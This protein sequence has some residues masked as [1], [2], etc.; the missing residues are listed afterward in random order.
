MIMYEPS[1]LL[2]TLFEGILIVVPF[3]A[4]EQQ[5][6]PN[7]TT[8]TKTQQQ[9]PSQSHSMMDERATRYLSDHLQKKSST[10]II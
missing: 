9:S 2:A 7:I 8:A 3:S 5:Q 4:L 10:N 6:P 1:A